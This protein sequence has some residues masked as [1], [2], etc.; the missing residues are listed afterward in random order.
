M[1]GT[2]AEKVDFDRL[3]KGF[4]QAL[5]YNLKYYF[6][7]KK[8]SLQFEVIRPL[9]G[10]MVGGYVLEK[11]KDR[12]R[13]KLVEHPFE[14]LD[15]ILER[16]YW[17]PRERLLIGEHYFFVCRK[18]RIVAGVLPRLLMCLSRTSI[19]L[20]ALMIER[21]FK[22]KFEI[23]TKCEC[24]KRVV[25]KFSFIRCKTSIPEE[26]IKWTSRNL[27]NEKIIVSRG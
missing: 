19:K 7:L 4:Y 25:G 10:Q 3:G 14:D 11:L 8:K 16:R 2:Y 22:E 21:A 1:S 24:L 20:P 27:N 15:V 13:I 12:Y 6:E 17:I 18:I 23:T 26:I 9:Q 5:Q